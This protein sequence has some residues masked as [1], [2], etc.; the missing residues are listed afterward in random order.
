VTGTIPKALV[1]VGGMSIL[2]RAVRRIMVLDPGLIVVNAHHHAGQIEAAV[3]RLNE[4]LAAETGDGRGED[5]GSGGIP[6]IIV[7]VEEDRPLETG[8]GLR[9]A[10]RLFKSGRPILL[11]NA[12]VITDFDLAALVTAHADAARDERAVATL[13][14]QRRDSSRQL[15]FDSNGLYGRR[16]VIPGRE[17]IA[18]TPVGDTQALAFA[19]VHV[20]APG[21]VAALPDR[22]VFSITDHYLELCAGGARIVQFNMETAGWW[23]IGTPERLEA[24][25]RALGGTAAGS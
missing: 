14:V 10:R 18:R 23:E 1:T 2:E 5:S 21:L 17:E 13:A 12:D 3:D 25:R 15:L 8:G 16:H 20:V 6:R 22:D 24:A 4:S 19:G 7:S 11:H 9:H